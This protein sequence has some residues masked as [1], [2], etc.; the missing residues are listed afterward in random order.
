MYKYT[1]IKKINKSVERNLQKFVLDTESTYRGQ[2][3]TVA[4]K[5]I[6]KKNVKIVLLAGPSCAGKTTTAKLIKQILEIKG[7]EV[8]VISMDDFFIDLDKR[9]K[10]PDGSTD[11]D[12]P[13][14]LNY[15]LMKEC[16]SKLFSGEDTYFPE[17][18]FKNSKSVPNSKLYKHKYN[19][20]VIF[21]GIHVLNPKLL[22]NLG[23]KDYFKLYVSPLNSFKNDEHN[24]TTKD[25][26]LLRRVV[27]DIKRRNTPASKTME[28][29][30]GVVDVEEKYIE[31]Y[32]DKVDYYVDTIQEYEM[33][34]YHSELDQFI[35]EGKIKKEE[36]PFG[37]IVF[38]ATPI[39]K[40][41]IPD[42]SL[43][44][45]FVDK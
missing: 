17:Y 36:V 20:I 6:A 28:I 39:S 34:V 43:M 12:S 16:F 26:R 44:W 10:L 22:K 4:N 5:I 24:M 11:Y 7:R 18:D 13:E 29:W 2:L 42:T 37:D 1:N 14:V 31:P 35:A 38:S 30:P 25:L 21:E 23:T 19:S 3:F 32:R 40:D 33:G 15:E 9:K 8:E 41:L 27:R 45:E